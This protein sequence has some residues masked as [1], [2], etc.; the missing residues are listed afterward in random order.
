MTEET[1]A[2]VKKDTDQ[3]VDIQ[4]VDKACNTITEIFSKHFEDAVL[5]TGKYLIKEFFD[6]ELEN[7]RVKEKEII[8]NSSKGDSLNQVFDYF[9]RDTSKGKS[10]KTPRTPSK[11]WLYQSIQFVIQETDLEES[12]S[13]ES[14]QTYGKLLLSHKIELLRLTDDDFLTKEKLILKVDKDSLTVRE[15]REEVNR[16]IKSTTR[17]IGILTI[18]NKPEL[19]LEQPEKLTLAKL[20]KEQLNKLVNISQKIE[21]KKQVLKKEL[22]DFENK[23]EAY[24][25]YLGK[26]DEL[27]SNVDKAIKD[28]KEEKGKMSK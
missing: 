23:T 26:F 7:A 4:L 10:D 17:N 3:E 25:Q 27:K 28:K 8:E 13:K 6:N 12:L 22:S 2:G 9:K 5:K 18:I 21:D 11:S 15:L 14:F 20:K 19:L 16:K 24:K 1:K